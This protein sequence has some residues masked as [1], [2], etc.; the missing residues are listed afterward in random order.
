MP[1]VVAVTP[2]PQPALAIA[3]VPAAAAPRSWS[4][5]RI[6][7]AAG[8]AVAALLTGWIWRV[9]HAPSPI[10]GVRSIAVLPLRTLGAGAADEIWVSG[11]PTL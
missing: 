6:G 4:R 9:A 3:P 5:R 8:I 1:V 2:A 7:V 11:S 10:L